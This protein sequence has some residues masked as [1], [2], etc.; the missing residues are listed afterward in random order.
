VYGGAPA[1]P[2]PASPPEPAPSGGASVRYVFLLS[3]LRS[4]QITM[5]EATE[6]FGIMQAMIRTAQTPSA[7]PPP[8]TG[9][10]AA[11]GAPA[12]APSGDDYW[13]SLLVLGAGA[14]IG[15]ALVKRLTA[16]SSG[17]PGPGRSDR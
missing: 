11:P 14:G 6:L 1:A 7:A 17:D 5:E 9:G 16:S 15:A 3:R 13:I 8:A 10:G 4:R 12:T 2:A